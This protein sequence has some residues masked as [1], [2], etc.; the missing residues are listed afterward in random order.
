[1]FC[2]GV[3][4]KLL[5]VECCGCFPFL[6]SLQLSHSNKTCWGI[7][8]TKTF[9][10][11]IH[12]FPVWISDHGLLITCSWQTYC[13]LIIPSHRGS[14]SKQG[15]VWCVTYHEVLWHHATPWRQLALS[16]GLP[17]NCRVVLTFHNLY[18]WI[19]CADVVRF[20]CFLNFWNPRMMTFW[21]NS[22]QCR[23]W[24]LE[25]YW[26]WNNGHS[27]V[28]CSRGSAI[29]WNVT[30]G[31]TQHAPSSWHYLKLFAVLSPQTSFLIL[32]DQTPGICILGW[33][34]S[35]ISPQFIDQY[36]NTSRWIQLWS[37][38]ESRSWEMAA[39]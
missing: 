37:S 20:W 2:A 36:G 5:W 26:N 7:L 13:V 8:A 34:F 4:E 39:T 33:R 24:Q 38:S 28:D 10:L 23:A 30:M 22:T 6:R 18:S 9:L 16:L 25:S 15:Q 21:G 3:L 27:K 19:I 32:D 1:M 31:S 35:R 12:L 29:I 14:R 17:F 11:L